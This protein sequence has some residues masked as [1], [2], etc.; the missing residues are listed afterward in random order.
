MKI[1]I[2]SIAA[3]LLPVALC[4]QTGTAGA[5]TPSTAAP[6]KKATTPAK[7]AAPAAP[8]VTLPSEP[9]TYAVFYTSLGNIVCRLFPEDAPK[10]VA[11]FKGLATGTKEW[12]DPVTSAK[13]KTPLYAGTIFHRVIPG[14]MI[15]GGDPSGTGMG[16]PVA[17]FGL[18]NSPKHDFNGPGVLAMA[19]TG[20]PNSN[21]SQFFITVGPYPSGNGNYTIFGGVVSGQE[22][23]NSISGVPRNADDKPYTPVKLIRVV[24]RTV[25]SATAAPTR[26]STTATP[27]KAA[28][29]A[30]T[31]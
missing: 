28:T 14:F 29:K 2:C 19:N 5:Q 25:P 7:A 17:G 3:V 13:K 8:A 10:A 16:M 4:T 31:N 24:I 20:R 30:T 11:N 1:A 27:A 21:G 22:V 6:A 15:Q 26:K 12:T 23:A 9:G 18:E